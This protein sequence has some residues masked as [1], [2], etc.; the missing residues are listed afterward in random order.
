MT[1]S[2]RKGAMNKAES[3]SRRHDF[4]PQAKFSWLWDDEVSSFADL[5]RKSQP[6]LGAAVFNLMIVNA[7]QLSTEVADLNREG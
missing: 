6:W 7:L 1:F 3:L 5:Q 2:F 4:I